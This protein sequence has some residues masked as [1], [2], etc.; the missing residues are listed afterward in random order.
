MLFSVCKAVWAYE[1]CMVHC[2]QLSGGQTYQ[3]IDDTRRSGESVMSADVT[4]KGDKAISLGPPGSWEVHVQNVAP[5]TE[6]CAD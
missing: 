2:D 3:A 6:V 4:I 5:L 1:E